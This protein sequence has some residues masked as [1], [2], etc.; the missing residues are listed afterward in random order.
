MTA[1]LDQWL[2]CGHHDVPSLRRRTPV[3]PLHHDASLQEA[4]HRPIPSV[5]QMRCRCGKAPNPRA[6]C[7]AG[8]VGSWAPYCPR[9]AA[10]CCSGCVLREQFRFKT[11]TNKQ[12]CKQCG[13]QAHALLCTN[14]AN[15]NT[16]SQVCIHSRTHARSH[17]RAQAHLP[18]SPHVRS[19]EGTHTCT[20]MHAYTLM[21]STGDRLTHRSVEDAQAQSR[22]KQT[23]GAKTRETPQS[24]SGTPWFHMA[25]ANLALPQSAGSSSVDCIRV[26]ALTSLP[27]CK[28]SRKGSN[29]F[30]G[31]E[32]HLARD[33]RE[34]Q[35]DPAA[36][37]HV[38]GSPP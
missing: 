7:S 11:L 19:Q 5:A 22:F 38:C 26:H 1:S 20:H 31:A 36:L 16:Q 33:R 35:A 24:S 12:T 34:T 2:S 29:C 28:W 14:A 37:R 27:P 32:R 21:P 25:K 4:S 17:A 10:S 18:A 3:M 15:K 8:T 30:V 23:G 9:G 13:R 6:H